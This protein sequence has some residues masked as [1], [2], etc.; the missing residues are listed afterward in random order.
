MA[1][2]NKTKQEI[3]ELKTQIK[4]LQKSNINMAQLN[5]TLVKTNQ[6]LSQNLDKS[7]FPNNPFNNLNLNGQPYLDPNQINTN[8]SVMVKQKMSGLSE[9]LGNGGDVSN[10]T[11][12]SYIFILERA[13]Y[14]MACVQFDGD[15]YKLI[16]L[17][18]KALYYG[19]L[20]GQI[21]IVHD[22]NGYYLIYITKKNYDKYGNVTKV[23]GTTFNYLN[24]SDFKQ[25]D[26]TISNMLQIV[27]FDFNNEDFGL[28]VLAWIYVNNLYRFL[29]ILLNQA[30]LLNKRF[31]LRSDN[32]NSQLRAELSSILHN[33][34]I[35]IW[36]ANDVELTQLE[37][38][39]FDINQIFTLIEN[40][41]NYF[42]F[43]FLNMRVKDVS[44]SDKERDIASQQANHQTENNN[45]SQFVDYF[46]DKMVFDINEKWNENISYKNR[47]VEIDDG[48]T[49]QTKTLNKLEG[50]DV[51][52]ESNQ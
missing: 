27:I 36:L 17:L 14:F 28:W 38:P 26:V 19:S 50:G 40:Y 22:E 41:T 51:E 20:N 18:Y 12:F 48:I 31:V 25:E 10:Q 21:G 47:T 44:D 33:Q 16:Q 7:L 2:L 5:D 24:S 8:M 37:T 52:H 29:T 45:K 1:L 11:W 23:E 4:D 42:D 39:D 43:H 34:S 3:E 46:I 15:N 6:T 9:E 30:D 49:N 32:N 35:L 13:K